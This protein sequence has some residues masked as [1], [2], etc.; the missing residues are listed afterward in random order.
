MFYGVI[1]FL[2]VVY[3]EDLSSRG[4]YLDCVG[5]IFYLD[6]MGGVY[7]C[8]IFILEGKN[9]G[10]VVF[11]LLWLIVFFI[12]LGLNFGSLFVIF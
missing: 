2:L 3:G 5:R 4:C 10:N 1:I 9:V 8:F 12:R 11:E 7:C 6:V